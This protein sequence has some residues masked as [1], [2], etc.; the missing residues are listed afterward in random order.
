MMCRRI[1]TERT[2]P[3]GDQMTQTQEKGGAARA[4][5][6]GLELREPGLLSG[7]HLGARLVTVALLVWLLYPW[8]GYVSAH[9]IEAASVIAALNVLLLASQISLRSKGVLVRLDADG[10]TVV[11]EPVVPWQ[12]LS[13][14]EC[15]GR[16]AAGTFMAFVPRTSGLELPLAPV[17]GLPLAS[18]R[19]RRA[20]LLAA[21]GSSLVVRPE[22]YGAS[23]AEV[24]AAVRRYGRGVPVFE[25]DRTEPRL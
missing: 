17:A 9:S 15:V 22:A 24:A 11:G 5:A 23:V 4:A 25:D 6:G 16:R 8:H 10:V 3:W 14:V 12:D 21:Y 18:A 1:V 19:R 20:R 2:I 13:K 7:G